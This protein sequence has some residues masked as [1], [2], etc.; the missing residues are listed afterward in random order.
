M[1]IEFHGFRY[2]RESAGKKLRTSRSSIYM[3]MK[4]HPGIVMMDGVRTYDH[5]KY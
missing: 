5:S 2:N 1:R 3:Q 4:E